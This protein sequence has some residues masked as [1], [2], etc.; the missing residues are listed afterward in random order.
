M[1]G[2]SAVP[3]PRPENTEFGMIHSM[4]AFARAQGDSDSGTLVWEIRSVNH[5]YLE[6][7]LRLPEEL[8]AK[9]GDIRQRIGA[10]LHRGKVDCAL[11]FARGTAG[12]EP[13]EFDE[14]RLNQ[15]LHASWRL[16]EH[17]SRL[18]PLAVAEVLQWPG[19]MRTPEIDVEGLAKQAFA[20]LDQV[21]SELVAVREREGG[22]L[23][24]MLEQ[25]LAAMGGIVAETRAFM[26]EVTEAYRQR[27]Q[28]RLAEIRGELDPA[29]VEQEIVLFAHKTDVHEELDR[30]DAHIAEV[31]RIIAGSGAV[32]RRLDFL[33]QELNREANTLGSKATDLRLTNASVELKV[34]IEQMREQVQNIE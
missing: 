8:R 3:S 15:L 12:E 19:V 30:L 16:H 9:E 5:R 33:M 31:R 6:I 29:R 28:E 26:P 17:D 25:R 13:L 14:A 21:L 11:R 20:A 24:R 34:L 7:S 10:R 4:T 18:R 32:G 23:A 1:E 22:E 27:L 2:A